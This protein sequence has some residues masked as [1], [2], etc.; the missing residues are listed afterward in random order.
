MLFESGIFHFKG[1][2]NLQTGKKLRKDTRMYSSTSHLK[3]GKEKISLRP[4]LWLEP[5]IRIGIHLPALNWRKAVVEDFYSSKL[6]P[7]DSGVIYSR[8]PPFFRQ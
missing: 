6:P 8:T 1:A 4:S 2:L 7:R 3:F 5:N